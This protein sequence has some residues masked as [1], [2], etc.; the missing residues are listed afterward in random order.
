[1]D[2]DTEL[3]MACPEHI[4]CAYCRSIVDVRMQSVL[5]ETRGPIPGDFI[6][7][8]GCLMISRLSI[9]PG[10]DCLYARKLTKEE[11]ESVAEEYQHFLSAVLMGGRPL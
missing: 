1:M 3:H 8:T 11:R 4:Y 2:E 10:F 6:I 9:I 7:C 5:D